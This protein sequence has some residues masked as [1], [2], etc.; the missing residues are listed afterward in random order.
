MADE[1]ALAELWER[2]SNELRPPEIVV[3]ALETLLRSEGITEEKLILDVAG[4]FGFPS[5]DLALRGWQVVYSDGSLAMLERAMRNADL[6]GAPG[7]LFTFQTVGYTALPW[8]AYPSEVANES[9]DALLCMG[10]SLPYVASWGKEAGNCNRGLPKIRKTLRQ[11]FRVLSPGGILYVDKQPESQV[12]EEETVGPFDVNG[13]TVN[14]T[15]IIDNDYTRSRRHWTLSVTDCE[16]SVRTVY[17]STGYLLSE[18]KLLS[19]LQDAGFSDI[20]KHV[21]DG[22]IY[23][24]FVA[25]KPA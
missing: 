10:N 21:L 15:C 16:R 22:E 24:G 4:G 1:H 12:H 19:L 5:I 17:P 18:E 13:R 25:R 20:Q 2:C 23:E 14:V 9:F 11:F 8:Q 7:Y 6:R 3:P